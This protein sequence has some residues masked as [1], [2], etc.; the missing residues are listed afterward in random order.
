M[1]TNKKIVH[2]RQ[3]IE[4]KRVNKSDINVMLRKMTNI[5][6]SITN[7]NV[8]QKKKCQCL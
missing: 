6:R 7:H 8:F 4:M 5:N 3:R 1:P 2:K